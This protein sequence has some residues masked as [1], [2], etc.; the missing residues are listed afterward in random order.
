MV[1]GALRHGGSRPDWFSGMALGSLLT[2]GTARTIFKILEAPVVS[3][4]GRYV[5]GIVFI[6]PGSITHKLAQ[7]LEL[8]GGLTRVFM[9]RVNEDYSKRDVKVYR[10]GV[11]DA[12][13]QIHWMEAVGVKCITESVPLHDEDTKRKNIPKIPYA[14]RMWTSTDGGNA[15]GR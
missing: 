11:E 3:V 1:T 7:Q 13:R 10:L 6:D 14:P 5:Q 2:E 9:K 8:E 12:K 15:V 4:E